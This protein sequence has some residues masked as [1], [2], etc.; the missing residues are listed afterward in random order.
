MSIL[1]NITSIY[2]AR[3]IAEHYAKW[4]K[5]NEKVL[6]VGCGNGVVTKF[7][8]ED[9]GV[10]IEGCDIENYLSKQIKFKIMEKHDELPYDD[11]SFD[12]VMFNDVLHHTSKTNQKKIDK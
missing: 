2:R 9:L 12:A 8:S 11:N 7:L 1:A 3:L 10:I 5:P 6:D 4:L